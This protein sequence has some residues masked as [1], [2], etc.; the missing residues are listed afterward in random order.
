MITQT[1]HQLTEAPS[2]ATLAASSVLPRLPLTPR[3]PSARLLARD[4]CL[5]PTKKCPGNKPSRA[6]SRSSLAPGLLVSLGLQ[7]A[8]NP[9]G[10]QAPVFRTIAVRPT[11]PSDSEARRIAGARL[12]D[13]AACIPV[14]PS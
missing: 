11:G 4:I 10:H 8:V 13:K 3:M 7:F 9:Q 14:T 5:F 6:A 12:G 1:R 2:R